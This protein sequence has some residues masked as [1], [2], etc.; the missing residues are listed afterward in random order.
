VALVFLFC[1]AI[2]AVGLANL[3]YLGD[4]MLRLDRLRRNG[5]VVT[6]HVV[7]RHIEWRGRDT[8]YVVEFTY[9]P[10][11][12]GA[13]S[14]PAISHPATKNDR[15]LAEADKALARAEKQISS[16]PALDV[17]DRAEKARLLRQLRRRNWL[18]AEEDVP[19]K[20]YESIRAD[21]DAPVTLVPGRAELHALGRVDR[22]R[23]WSVLL[24]HL[25]QFAAG[26]VFTATG[27]LTV[28]T[29]L[30]RRLA[31]SRPRE[32]AGC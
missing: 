1:L 26:V 13:G 27:L 15:L 31:P 14:A 18:R 10:G 12:G 22:A 4:E 5:V 9:P 3:W 6:G 25:Y 21:Q 20:L 2:L 32:G 23:V 11:K 30:V 24:D 19:Y 17:A 7:S 28:G 29:A 8:S 16:W